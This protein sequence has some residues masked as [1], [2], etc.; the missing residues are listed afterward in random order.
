MPL[1][2]CDDDGHKS[3]EKKE[4]KRERTNEQRA[5]SM[6]A[7][8]N[9]QSKT[10]KRL[11]NCLVS[12]S[13]KYNNNNN[14]NNNNKKKMSEEMASDN[15]SFDL[16]LRSFYQDDRTQFDIQ[17]NELLDQSRSRDMQ[18]C[19]HVILKAYQQE[20]FAFLE[21]LLDREVIYSGIPNLTALHA[22]S[23]Y[24][25]SRLVRYLL[26]EK[27]ADPNKTCTFIKNDQLAG[28]YLASKNQRI[29]PY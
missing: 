18:L 10:K 26:E 15:S 23:G 17:L 12:D 24:G 8:M 11:L 9:N 27:K 13:L 25:L 2:F 29:H 20:E 14:Y 1:S 5:D 22:A 4:K 7:Q 16:L 28:K 19:T 21:E 3:T 6:C